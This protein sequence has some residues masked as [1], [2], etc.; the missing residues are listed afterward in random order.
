MVPK[1][2]AD[3]EK[4]VKERN[5]DKVK[6]KKKTGEWKFLYNKLNPTHILTICHRADA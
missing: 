3:I 6:K 5:N 2:E 1:K 4:K